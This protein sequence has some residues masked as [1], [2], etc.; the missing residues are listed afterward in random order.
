MGQK[1]RAE[2]IVSGKVQGV[3]Y[4]ER[5]RQK[6]EKLGITGWVKNLGD[7]RVE[8]IFEGEKEKVEEMVDWA[9]SGP[10]WAKVDGLDLVWEDYKGEFQN[11]E[12]R[13]DF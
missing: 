7:G 2:I 9:R 10:I 4:R 12:I 5:T 11:F 6:A 1:V 13:Y 8:A 3:F